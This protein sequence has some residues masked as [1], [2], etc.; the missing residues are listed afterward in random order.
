MTP[1]VLYLAN[2]FTNTRVNCV[3][4]IWEVGKY[5]NTILA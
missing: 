1:H 4:F 2:D 5:N 3:P